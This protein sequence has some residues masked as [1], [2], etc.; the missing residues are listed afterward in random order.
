M[1]QTINMP[2]AEINERLR[3]NGVVINHGT[4]QTQGYVLTEND[5]HI[6]GMVTS[7]DISSGLTLTGEYVI[8]FDSGATPTTFTYPATLKWKSTPFIEPNTRYYVY[9]VRGCA[10]MLGFQ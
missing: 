6:W 7:L 8:Q 9:I 5:T 10:V 2:A 4:G 3:K 1:S